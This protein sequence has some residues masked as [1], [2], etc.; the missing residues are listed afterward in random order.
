MTV[1]KEKSKTDEKFTRRQSHSRKDDESD[2][3][4]LMKDLEKLKGSFDKGQDK[5][6]GKE[7]DKLLENYR[8][9]EQEKK[10]KSVASKKSSSPERSSRKSESSDNFQ[11]PKEK[12]Y[13]S[14][15]KSAISVVVDV[16]KDE[17]DT[18]D[19][20]S[21]RKEE[22]TPKKNEKDRKKETPKKEDS[23]KKDE[24]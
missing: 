23:E 6:I 7:Y 14:G 22:N 8:L 5:D 4:I 21:S 9:Y 16:R 13:K 2:D 3:E 12:V 11:K 10:Q 18:K 1:K 20:K 15:L 19:E 17:K 24:K